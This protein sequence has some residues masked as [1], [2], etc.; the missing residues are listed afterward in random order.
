MAALRSVGRNDQYPGQNFRKKRPGGTSDAPLGHL[1]QRLTAA[2][3]L[4]NGITL[5]SALLAG[6]HPLTD[7]FADFSVRTP[8]PHSEC[9]HLGRTNWFR[10]QE[11]T[12]PH[13]LAAME[14]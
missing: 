3:K 1:Y 13:V 12:Q 8:L 4:C 9:I 7:A 14:T 2:G 6:Q 5:G 11:M 10:C